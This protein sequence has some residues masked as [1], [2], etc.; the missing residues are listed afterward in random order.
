MRHDK[1]HNTFLLNFLLD[2]FYFNKHAGKHTLIAYRFSTK[3]KNEP[4]FY[5]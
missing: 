2:R 5:H 1:N 4:A 3:H